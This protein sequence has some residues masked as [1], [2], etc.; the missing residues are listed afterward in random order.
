MFGQWLPGKVCWESSE[1]LPALPTRKTNDEKTLLE[2]K[3]VLALVT[4]KTIN[5]GKI[6]TYY[7]FQSFLPTCVYWKLRTGLPLCLKGCH[8]VGLKGFPSVKINCYDKG[9][10]CYHYWHYFFCISCLLNFFTSL[11]NR[12]PISNIFDFIIHL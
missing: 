3:I 9:Y 7:I 1:K 11:S 4:F 8:L 12:P 5:V 10:N 6:C 2:L